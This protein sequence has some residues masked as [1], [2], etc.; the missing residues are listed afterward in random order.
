MLCVRS[1]KTSRTIPFFY[2]SQFSSY[3]PNAPLDLDKSF[4]AILRDLD[5]AAPE[6]KS[7]AQHSPHY[8]HELTAYPSDPEPTKLMHQDGEVDVRAERKSPAALFGSQQL[9]AVVI[10]QELQQTISTLI[11]ESDRRLL[12]RDAKRL[13]NE[14]GDDNNWV[15]ALDVRYKSYKQARRHAERDGTAFASVVLPAH[16]SAIYAV[17]H[18]IRSR[19]GPQWSVKNVLDWG[20]GTGSALWAAGHA[21][22][23]PPSDENESHQVTLS[24]TAI[25]KYVGIEKRDGLV[26]IARRLLEGIPHDNLDISW[27]RKFHRDNWPQSYDGSQTIAVSAFFLSTLQT[28]LQRKALMKEMW[29]SGADIIVL[30][31]HSSPAGF[32]GVA[33]AREYLLGMGQKDAES[34]ESEGE[35]LSGSHVLAPCPHDGVCPIHRSNVAKLVCGFSQR[36][37]RPPFVRRTKHSGIGH[38][39]T[40]YSYVVIRRGPRPSIPDVKVGRMGE[41]GRRQMQHEEIKR[42]L[43]ELELDDTNPLTQLEPAVA[44]I[45]SEKSSKPYA[46]SPAEIGNL[47]KAEAFH[48]PRLVFPPLKKSGHVVMDVCAPSGRVLRMTVPKSQGKQPYYDARKSGWG[49]IFPHEPKNPPQVRFP[50][51]QDQVHGGQNTNPVA[52]T[53]TEASDNLPRL[54][55]QK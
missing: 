2:F 37:E 24:S 30:L 12:R 33:E 1:V 47:L 22:L 13:F 42:P 46:H 5:N 23:K 54:S 10:P 43:V 36:M 48:W 3:Q 50:Q 6:Q 17:L 40:G 4:K 16:Y 14:R 51:P 45:P 32:R 15:S 9:G 52:D 39:D 31:D 26:V 25:V 19:L 18:H 29:E 55:K 7:R 27:Q 20:A 38:E 8:I 11:S 49:D 41:V 21:F 34:N 44:P 28:S 35:V 53:R